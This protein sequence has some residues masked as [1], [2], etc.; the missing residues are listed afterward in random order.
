MRELDLPG[1][2]TVFATGGM[3]ATSQPLATITAI[4]ILQRGGNAMDAAIAAVAVQCVVEPQ[5]TGIGGDCFCLYS[6][7]GNGVIAFNGSGRAPA[8]ATVDWYLKQDIGIIEQHTPHAVT[9]PGAVDAWSQM[10]ADH[11]S[12]G[13]GEVL[14]PAIRFATDG[15]PVHHR[16]QSDW[17]LCE[18]TLAHDP[19]AAKYYL[20]DGK[21]PAIGSLVKLPLLATSLETIAEKG[22]AGF[23]EGSIAEDIQ[24]FLK[25]KGGLHT[26]DDF[27]GAHGEYVTPIKTNYR[28]Y[29]V[30][31]C[32]PNGQGVVALAMLNILSGFDLGAFD[33]VST[34][35]L[36]LEI[37]AAR[38]AYRDR[39]AVLGDPAFSE[40]P[41]E[42]WLSDEHADA[43]RALIDPAKCM[44][45]LPG[46]N[47]PRHEDTVYLTVVDKDRNAVS[48]INTLFHSFGSGLV[49][50]KSGVVLQNRGQ[51]FVINPGH[52]NCIAPNKRPLHTIIPGMLVKNGRAQMPFGVMGGQYQAC[53]HAHLLT[54]ILDWDMDLQGALDMTRVFPDIDDPGGR[55]QV[56]SGLPVD[57]RQGLEDLGHETYIPSRP[58]GGAQAIWIDWQ[59]G[60]LRGASEPRKDGMAIGY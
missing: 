20:R 5:S 48:F 54:N 33:P 37:E 13:M 27:A 34:E 4:E 3:A 30:Y 32:P 28:G 55:V 60:V 18:A 24:S 17:S 52:P 35:R 53:G 2:S 15:F 38:L 50:P 21:A 44:A 36:H 12:L 57:V 22:R 31:E 7:G 26:M 42:R 6:P 47:L 11:G 29:D 59:E 51:G 14:E 8:A 25:S 16:T 41:V 45:P 40:I 9:I 1:R 23:Y 58:I 46:S 10:L 39:T 43:E 49:A 56:E 19:T